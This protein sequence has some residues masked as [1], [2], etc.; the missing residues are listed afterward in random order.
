MKIISTPEG[1]VFRTA[2]AT[3]VMASRNEANV[4]QEQLAQAIGWSKSRLV[5]VE[6]GRGKVDLHEIFA[7]ARALGI[8]PILMMIRIHLWMIAPTIAKRY[9]AVVNAFNSDTSETAANAVASKC[10]SQILREFSAAV[11]TWQTFVQAQTPPKVGDG[12]S[13]ADA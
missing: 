4:S 11:A 3:I 1:Q 2:V 8:D 9:R 5:R 7:I 12:T 6:K 13:A 10:S